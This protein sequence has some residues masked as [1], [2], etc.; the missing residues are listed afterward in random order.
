MK[1]SR[2]EFK[3]I[4]IFL[5]LLLVPTATFMY[6]TRRILTV[7]LSFL[8]NERMEEALS[9]GL[10]IARRLV[11][12]EQKESEA[13]AEEIR[14]QLPVGRQL[15]DYDSQQQIERYLKSKVY[16]VPIK[17]IQIINSEGTPMWKPERKER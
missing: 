9:E 14:A 4:I 16:A 2:F 10:E 8:A 11:E 7:S 3:L 1:I 12:M 6:L 17:S 5:A 15:F 13:I